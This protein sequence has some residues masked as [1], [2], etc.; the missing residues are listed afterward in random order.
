M[1]VVEAALKSGSLITARLATDC[2]RE[3]FAIPGSIHLAGRAGLSPADP[4]RRQARRSGRRH[5]RRVAPRPP[6]PAP[7][8]DPAVSG[9]RRRAGCGRPGHDPVDVDTLVHR[10]SLT[11]GS[12][13][14]HSA[15][16]GTRRAVSACPEGASSDSE[17][18]RP[19][20][21]RHVRH[22]R[23]PL[24]ELRSTPMRA[25]EPAHW[26]AS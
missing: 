23:V 1:L 9:G 20:A 8:G 13:L 21:P 5:P 10:T 17:N 2:G 15:Y 3:V 22:P 25:P 11:P 18:D 26:P 4:R 12:A 24:R 14:R 19:Q 7:A 6:E 16:A